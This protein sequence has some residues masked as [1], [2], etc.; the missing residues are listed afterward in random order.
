MFLYF[1]ESNGKYY[2][3][4][5]ELEPSEEARDVEKQTKLWE[6]SGGYLKM[7]GFEPLEVPPEPVKEEKKKEEEKKEEKAEEGAAAA[8]SAEGE[9]CHGNCVALETVLSWKRSGASSIC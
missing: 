2:K 4:G 3:N 5:A 6:L 9:C 1:S 8:A 7:E